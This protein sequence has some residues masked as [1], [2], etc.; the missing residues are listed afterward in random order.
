MYCT[1]AYGLQTSLPTAPVPAVLTC[2][3]WLR[4]AGR[5]GLLPVMRQQLEIDE[6]RAAD[7]SRALRHVVQGEGLGPG[8]GGYA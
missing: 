7:I 5:R 6:A 3:L 8:G 1:T 4:V 2:T